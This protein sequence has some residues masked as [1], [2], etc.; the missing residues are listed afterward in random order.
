MRN[1]NTRITNL[2]QTAVLEDKYSSTLPA[3][4]NIRDGN[5][6][7]DKEHVSGHAVNL[8]TKQQESHPHCSAVAIAACRERHTSRGTAPFSCLA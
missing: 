3:G 4:M 8:V 1:P 6:M 7:I 2:V 5:C